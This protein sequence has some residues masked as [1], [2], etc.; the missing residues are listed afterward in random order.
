LAFGFDLVLLGPVISFVNALLLWPFRT[1]EASSYLMASSILGVIVWFWISSF[2][3]VLWGATP[4]KIIMK[5]KVIPFNPEHENFSPKYT[6]QLDWSAALIRSLVWLGGCFLLGIPFLSV[7]KDQ[8]RRVAHDHWSRTMLV[9]QKTGDDQ[10]PLEAERQL[11]RM[12]QRGSIAVFAIYAVIVGSLVLD[13]TAFSSLPFQVTAV[14]SEENS[15]C[16]GIQST[17]NSAYHELDQLMV[18]FK[19]DLISK[20]CLLETSARYFEKEAALDRSWAALAKGMAV[21]SDWKL[22]S[23]YLAESCRQAGEE[24]DSCQA[25]K[26]LKAESSSVQGGSLL[27]QWLRG[28]VQNSHPI[29]SQL[30]DLKNDM[31]EGNS[32]VENSFKLLTMSLP[33]GNYHRLQAKICLSQLT[34]K[35]E[36][37]KLPV[38]EGVAENLETANE[39][40]T[41][42]ES[43]RWSDHETLAWVEYQRCRRAPR[44]SLSDWKSLMENRADIYQF[45]KVLLGKADGSVDESKVQGIIEDPSQLGIIRARALVHLVHHEQKEKFFKDFDFAGSLKK[46]PLD[47]FQVSLLST[48][49]QRQYELRGFVFTDTTDSGSTRMPAS[50]PE[51]K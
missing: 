5:M 6:D 18:Y 47:P 51:E 39:S 28:E 13:S 16:G 7:F 12:L 43:E 48:S 9:S 36:D 21:E 10:G 46:L 3:L 15:I 37:T 27:S 17:F 1:I 38:C 19:A 29:L 22:F 20:D 44:G 26:G 33:K 4:G 42:R 49:L 23:R 14:S 45:A 35:C 2:F 25:G 34:Y 32:N 11:A 31:I 50:A 40:L 41:A 30:Q 8:K 24:S